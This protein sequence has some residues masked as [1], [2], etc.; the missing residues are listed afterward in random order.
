MAAAAPHLEDVG[1]RHGVDQ[2]QQL[3]GGLHQ[4]AAQ[5]ALCA[6][7]RAGKASAG[8]RVCR[9]QSQWTQGSKGSSE[10]SLRLAP[11][12]HRKP[13]HCLRRPD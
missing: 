4:L 9:A 1:G 10:R 5:R 7:G 6:A 12:I 2:L 11:S 13:V 8:R 3:G